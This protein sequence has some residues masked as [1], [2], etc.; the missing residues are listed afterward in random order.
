MYFQAKSE[1]YLLINSQLK[2]EN[3]L[4][5]AQL[6]A[7]VSPQ[8][9]NPECIE[10]PTFASSPTPVV[11]KDAVVREYEE[12]LNLLQQKIVDLES[13]LSSSQVVN[14]EITAE[15]ERLKTDQDDLLEL[16]ADH[17]SILFFI[18][19]INTLL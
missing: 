11:D 12:K 19:S 7:S 6:A 4:L 9:V 2:D 14:S 13:K 5:K 8:T 16:L 3:T 15:M 10:I 1:E 17:V 18:C